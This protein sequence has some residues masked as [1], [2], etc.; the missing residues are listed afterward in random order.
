MN[1]L[2]LKFSLQEKQQIIQK[3]KGG[4]QSQ[5]KMFTKLWTD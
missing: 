3:L 2:G 1:W 5:Q 4:L